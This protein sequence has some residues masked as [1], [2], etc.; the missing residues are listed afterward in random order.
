LK[1]LNKLRNNWLIAILAASVLL[2]LASAIYM[3]DQVENLPGTADQVSYHALALRVMGGEGFSFEENWWPATAAGTPTAHWSFLYTFYLVF[4]YGVFGVHPLAARLIQAIIVGVL[5]PYLAYWIGKKC[6]G[7]RTGLI[8]GAITA[9][10][11]Y[12]IYYAGCLMTEP[13]YMTAIMGMFA[14]V[15]SIEKSDVA[16][17]G[18][19][20][21]KYTGLGVLFGFIVLLRQLFL[22]IIPFIAIWILY[23][24]GWNRRWQTVFRLILAGGIVLAMIFPFTIYNYL[25]FHRV[26]LLNTNSGYA[27]FFG[28]H[29][30]YGTHFVPILPE[31]MGTYQQLI[32]KELLSLDEAALDQELM[33]RGI[34]FVVDDPGRYILLSISRIPV[35]FQF[36]PSSESGS[37]S[38][39]SRVVS[40]GIFLP[41]M[42][43][44]LFLAG[45]RRYFG[46]FSN[47]VW[48]LGVFMLPYIGMHLLTWALIRYRLPVDASLIIFSAFAIDDIYQRWW[49]R[50]KALSFT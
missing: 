23:S 33:K 27:F 12:F 50:R 42:V 21:L 48:L 45:F 46:K 3:G 30:I 4:V 31:E 39:L 5:Q 6:F 11:A 41:F 24:Q 9:G 10:Y 28:N 1:I 2:R 18:Q 13:F 37:I 25:R 15:F 32:P 36:W 19:N 20:W 16:K 44:G 26:V 47:Q 7:E 8:A 14:V 34:Q 35:Y 29:P 22:L 40:F 43:F 17:T 49:V 38:N